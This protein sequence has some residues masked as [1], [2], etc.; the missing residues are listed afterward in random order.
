M[1]V[2]LLSS[3]HVRSMRRTHSWR[4]AVTCNHMENKRVELL[5]RIGQDVQDDIAEVKKLYE[6][7][8]ISCS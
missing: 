1:Q 2:F 5:Q 7:D 6:E 4:S 3:V 8:K